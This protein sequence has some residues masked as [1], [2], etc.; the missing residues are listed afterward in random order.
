[1]VRNIVLSVSEGAAQTADLAAWLDEEDTLRGH[2]RREA[3]PVPE[4]ALGGDL[5]QLVV[6]LASGGVA[7]AA[8]SV[9]VAWLRRR[10]GSV[11]VRV[12]RPDGFELE[13]NAD[14]VRAMDA[15][16]LRAQV[17]QLFS[18]AWPDGPGHELGARASDTGAVRSDASISGPDGE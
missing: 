15:I 4:G 16:Q 7:T 12:T 14:R 8:A 3:S 6:G 9:I 2:V 10:T 13:V 11:S 5:Q 17:D 1:M 18:A